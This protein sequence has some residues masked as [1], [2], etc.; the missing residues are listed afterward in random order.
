MQFHRGLGRFV[1]LPPL[2]AP[3]DLL[4]AAETDG[5][6]REGLEGMN[7]MEIISAE[8][9]ALEVAEIE[10]EEPE[11]IQAPLFQVE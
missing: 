10:T 11:E 6:D 7:E 3:E 2:P 9:H 8:P 4:A 5:Q 1:Y